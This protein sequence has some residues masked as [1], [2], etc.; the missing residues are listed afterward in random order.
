MPRGG[1]RSCTLPLPAAGSPSGIPRSGPGA[2]RAVAGW[3][4][5][6]VAAPGVEFRERHPLKR[7]EVDDVGVM[8]PEFAQLEPPQRRE[9]PH[10]ARYS[11][12]SDVDQYPD[13]SSLLSEVKDD[14]GDRSV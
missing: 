12:R 2:S 7:A 9:I 10:A 14:S 3:W 13:T 5:L 4:V 6:D 1:D 8:D 11:F